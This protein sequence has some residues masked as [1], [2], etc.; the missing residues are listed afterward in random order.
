MRIDAT[1]T[2]EGQECPSGFVF[3]MKP[4]SQ[5]VGHVIRRLRDK[6]GWRQRDLATHSKLPVRTIGRIE[7]GQVDVRLSTLAKIAKALNVAAK[8]L[9]P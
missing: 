6:R 9:L 1:R 3:F 8:E 4:L 7:R 5:K 2:P